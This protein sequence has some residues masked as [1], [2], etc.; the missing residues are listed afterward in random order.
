MYWLYDHLEE[1]A[2]RTVYADTDSICL[3]LTK[4]EPEH[5][6]ATKEEQLRALFDPLVKASMRTSWEASWKDWFV[7]TSSVEDKRCPGKL[8]GTPQ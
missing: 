3:A 1:R 2:F 5:D 4:S 6:G 8:K 7:T